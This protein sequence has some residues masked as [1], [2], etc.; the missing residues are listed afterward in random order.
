MT[1]YQKVVQMYFI[2]FLPN[3]RILENYHYTR[4]PLASLFSETGESVESFFRNRQVLKITSA[5]SKIFRQ[6]ACVYSDSKFHGTRGLLNK[7]L[8]RTGTVQSTVPEITW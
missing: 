2:R 6:S 5:R 7:L 1:R 3:Q 4:L 8:I